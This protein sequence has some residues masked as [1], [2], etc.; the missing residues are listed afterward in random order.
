V[1][2]LLQTRE[3]RFPYFSDTFQAL[4]DASKVAS[5]PTCYFGTKSKTLSKTAWSRFDTGN[6]VLRRCFISLMSTFK[7]Y[8]GWTGFGQ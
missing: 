3:A 2:P 6:R 1:T 8:I 7:R 4:T 5:S